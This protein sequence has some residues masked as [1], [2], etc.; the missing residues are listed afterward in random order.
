[1]RHTAAALAHDPMTVHLLQETFFQ[2]STAAFSFLMGGLH[3]R[4]DEIRTRIDNKENIEAILRKLYESAKK[5]ARLWT[6]QIPLYLRDLFWTIST[7]YE[8]GSTK[9]DT[10]VRRVLA[11]TFNR[12]MFVS[13]NYDLLL[14][15][16]LERYVPHSFKTI[17]SYIPKNKMWCLI[18]PHGSVNWARETDNFPSHLM[19][20]DK[21]PSFPKG[22]EIKIIMRGSNGYYVP[23]TVPD[24]SPRRFPYPHLIIPADQPKRFTCP[25]SHIKRARAFISSCHTFLFIGFSGNDE[26]M[27]HLLEIMPVGSRV[28][29]VGCNGSDAETTLQNI[30]SRA[31]GLPKKRLITSFYVNDFA[32]FIDGNGLREILGE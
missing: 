5:N 9:Y 18:K 3:G 2:T 31:E 16:A 17:D 19:E 22:S 30:Y 8:T 28:T 32:D 6:F 27:A 15:R 14:D 1:V 23:N 11:S 29:I 25:P 13:L 26:D 24:D 4:T 20:F 7:D 21:R 12:V 10:L